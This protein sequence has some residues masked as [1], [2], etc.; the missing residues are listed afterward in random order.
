MLN[1]QRRFAAAPAHAVPCRHNS[2]AY[3]RPTRQATCAPCP[4]QCATAAIHR[5]PKPTA[6]AKP[7]PP[8]APIHAGAARPQ[9]TAA[10]L[11]LAWLLSGPCTPVSRRHPMSSG[12]RAAGALVPLDAPGVLIR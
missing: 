11:L 9:P 6:T 2:M 4:S 1:S 8:A 12:P 5:N 10:D 3:R 7:L